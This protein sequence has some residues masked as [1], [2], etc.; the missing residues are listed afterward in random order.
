MI[1]FFLLALILALTTAQPSTRMDLNGTARYSSVS[2]WTCSINFLQR[3]AIVHTEPMSS[4]Y[5]F[6]LF[7]DFDWIEVDD[8]NIIDTVSWSGT[9]CNCWIILFDD[10]GY[11]GDTLGLWTYNSTQGSY[12]LT[13]Y[14]YLYDHDAL[15]DENYKQWNN[16]VNAYKIYCY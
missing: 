9:S 11:E 12:D 13:T 16:A 1:K 14:N 10:D 5:T 4:S 2:G 7:S 3:T 15:G 6:A 8:A